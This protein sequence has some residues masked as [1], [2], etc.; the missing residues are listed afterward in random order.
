VV[1]D[2]SRA[3]AGIARFALRAPGGPLAPGIYWYRAST[4]TATVLG[5]FV[6]LE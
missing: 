2:E 5:R 3:E 1:A 4:A 6:V